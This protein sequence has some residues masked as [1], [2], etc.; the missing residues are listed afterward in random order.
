MNGKEWEGMG[1]DGEGKG[2]EGNEREGKGRERRRIDGSGRERKGLEGTGMNRTEQEGTGRE[3]N[4]RE[5][6]VC[7]KKKPQGG[8]IGG[9]VPQKLRLV[10][11]ETTRS[12]KE[13]E[14]DE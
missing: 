8:P 6:R 11:G 14:M 3:V 7:D 2:K 4:G 12:S 9:E 1:R 5:G 13:G 10:V